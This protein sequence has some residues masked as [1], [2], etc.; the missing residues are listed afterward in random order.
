MWSFI[1]HT[2]RC[3]MCKTA[4]SLLRVFEVNQ[5]DKL[6]NGILL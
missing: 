5:E 1:G 3:K 4:F 2:T 6:T